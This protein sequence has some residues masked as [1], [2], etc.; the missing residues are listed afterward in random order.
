MQLGNDSPIDVESIV[1]LICTDADLAAFWFGL[2]R[3]PA[4][5]VLLEQGLKQL[6]A[7]QLAGLFSLQAS[8]YTQHPGTARLSFEQWSSVLESA[9]WGSVL[10]RMLSRADDQRFDTPLKFLLAL[11]GVSQVEDQDVLALERFR[12]VKP[13]LLEDASVEHQIFAVISS[14]E[15][16]EEIRLGQLLLNLRPDEL[17]LTR[18]TARTEVAQLIEDLTLKSDEDTNCSYLIWL[19][20]HLQKV[21]QAFSQATD[22]TELTTL[23]N[24]FCGSLFSTVPLIFNREMEADHLT[25]SPPS[26]LSIGV[27]SATSLMAAAFR[28]RQ[29]LALEESPE[30]A[31]VD[32]QILDQVAASEALIVPLQ[33]QDGEA[34]QGVMVVAEGEDFDLVVTAAKYAE[35]LA[36]HLRQLPG[37]VETHQENALEEVMA[38]RQLEQARLRELV[39]EANNPLSIVHNYLHILELRLGHDEEAASQLKLISAELGR[40]GEIFTKAREVPEPPRPSRTDD[41]QVIVETQVSELEIMGWVVNLVQVHQGLAQQQGV[42][43][44]VDDLEGLSVVMVDAGKLTQIVGNLLKNALEATPRNGTVNVNCKTKVYRQGVAGVMIEI[45]DTGPGLPEDV[46]DTLGQPQSSTKGG[47]HQG[48]G[49]SVVHRLCQELNIALDISV[50]PG[51]TDVPG[52]VG[53]ARGLKSG[54]TFALFIPSQFVGPATE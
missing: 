22:L 44:L 3:I 37:L 48:L 15:G 41:E 49:L 8:H 5:P 25:Q 31:V 39:H 35:V 38:F 40:A 30:L 46:L 45:T 16:I 33:G 2:I 20:Q 12:G 42:N 23:H 14:L 28:E 29:I 52:V 51:V 32:Q 53:A 26:G 13:E 7:Q 11:S 19:E 1:Q 18:S 54:S 50:I 4:E 24:R 36:E 34:A 27:Q 43:L 10:W 6:P 21:S 9:T 17:E 47:D